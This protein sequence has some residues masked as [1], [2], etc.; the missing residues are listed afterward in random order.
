MPTGNYKFGQQRRSHA[1]LRAPRR[2]V[3]ITGVDARVCASR[4]RLLSIAEGGNPEVCAV[5]I[6]RRSIVGSHNEEDSK[7]WEAN[8]Y[9]R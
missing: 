8:I 3:F 9:L 4:T 7:A 2:Q 5:E 1:T 6:R